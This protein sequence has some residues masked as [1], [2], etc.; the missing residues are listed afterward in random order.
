MDRD[1]LDSLIE[2][3]PRSVE[4]LENLP[5][6]KILL[7]VGG[8]IAIGIGFFHFILSL[9][10]GSAPRLILHLLIDIFF[11]LSLLVCYV[12]IERK[13]VNWSA[14]AVISSLVLIALGGIVGGLAGIISIF[15]GA[16]AFFK[17]LG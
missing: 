12:R 1:L 4:D 17:N 2:E 8:Y 3:A 14:L 13:P 10:S 5:L 9:P 6:Y 15:G 16:L 7:A 11:G